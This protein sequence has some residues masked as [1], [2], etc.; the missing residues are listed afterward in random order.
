MIISLSC[1]VLAS[2][3]R[4]GGPVERRSGTFESPDLGLGTDNTINW[5][6]FLGCVKKRGSF[7]PS[8]SGENHPASMALLIICPFF[9]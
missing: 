7:K 5:G 2:A 8:W 6:I 9:L 1:N 3:Y 4:I